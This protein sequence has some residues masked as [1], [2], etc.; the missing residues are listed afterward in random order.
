MAAAPAGATPLVL[1]PGPLDPPEEPVT[2]SE[3]KEK[4]SWRSF[5]PWVRIDAMAKECARRLSY[6]EYGRGVVRP[7]TEAPAS[8]DNLCNDLGR[9]V[10]VK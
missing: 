9:H 4:W 7:P 6:M 5:S 1:W 10:G 2:L 8:A 3:I